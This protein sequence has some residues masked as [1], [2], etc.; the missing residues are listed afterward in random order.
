MN[1]QWMRN[2]ILSVALI[3]C[4]GS[5]GVAVPDDE[6][7]SAGDWGRDLGSR[8]DDH[9]YRGDDDF[10]DDDDGD[11]QI[12][13]VQHAVPHISTVP[14]IAGE[15]VE[16]FA[17]ERVKAS[18]LKKLGKKPPTGRVVLFI[19]GGSVP[20]VPGFDLDYKDYSW[21][22]ALA[23]AGFDVFSMDRTGY[24]FSPRPKMDDP[25]NVNPAQQ[26]I[27]IPHPLAAPCAPS[28]P[29]RLTHK[30]SDNDD[31]G[32]VVD[33]IRALRRVDRITIAGWSGVGP[34]AGSYAIKNQEKLDKL[35]FYAPTY[36]RTS[37]TNPPA[38]LPQSG[39]P[40]NL[41]TR[42]SLEDEWDSM[43]ACQNQFEPEIRSVVWN[44]IMDFEPVGR[45]WGPLE[46]VMRVRTNSNWGWNAVTSPTLKVPMLIIVGQNDTLL[47]DARNL[48]QD[49]GAEDKVLVEVPCASH[50]L[51]WE[52]RHK[53]LHTAS[54]EWLRRG[55]LRGIRQGVLTLDADGRLVPVP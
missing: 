48:H 55:S 10:D 39:F 34:Q 47:G 44:R 12:L 6:K 30:D 9:D 21:M 25:C 40:M 41:R 37:P 23:R 27:L 35:V 52:T 2:S 50:F 16:L 14:A 4:L 20:S 17:W 28:Y 13:A 42:P 5:P 15:H 18:K 7:R 19:H 11:K 38:T 45:T 51:V 31:I 54:K 24:G 3:A 43:V 1:C 53:I 46:G 33:Y 26:S 29:F 32:A 36:M 49:L 8:G 22:E